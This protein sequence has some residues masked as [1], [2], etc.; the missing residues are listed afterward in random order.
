[1]VMRRRPA[2]VDDP[3]V[4]FDIPVHDLDGAIRGLVVLLVAIG[5]LLIASPVQPQSAVKSCRIGLVSMG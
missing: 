3:V 2:M 1:M 4:W 5:A